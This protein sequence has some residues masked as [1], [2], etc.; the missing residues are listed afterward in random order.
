MA[1]DNLPCELPKDSSKY[2]GNKI[3]EHILPLFTH[4]E[5]LVLERATICQDGDLTNNFEYLRDFVSK[6]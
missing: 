5:N 6:D 2:F 1:V 3:I 4:D